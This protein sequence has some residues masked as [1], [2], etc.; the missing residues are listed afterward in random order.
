M[1]SLA[2]SGRWLR[3]RQSEVLKEPRVQLEIGLN[4]TKRIPA[5]VPTMWPQ[6]SKVSCT[7][8]WATPG[9]EPFMVKK[10]FVQL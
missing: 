10:G 7:V 1:R 4:R 9:A 2:P 3:W 6:S 5:S 8:G